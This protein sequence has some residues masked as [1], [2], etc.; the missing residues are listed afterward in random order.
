MF[1]LQPLVSMVYLRVSLGKWDG[2]RA[3]RPWI[4]RLCSY[5]DLVAC[6]SQNV[7]TG[8]LGTRSSE[9]E[10][11]IDARSVSTTTDTKS[12]DFRSRQ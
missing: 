10:V 5:C 8:R 1:H 2:G 3:D 4:R 7:E 9:H 12:D 6:K 11:E